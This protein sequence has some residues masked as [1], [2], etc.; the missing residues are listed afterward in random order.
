M[1][2]AVFSVML[3]DF[4]DTLGTVTGLA[5][6]VGETWLD[7]AGRLPRMVTVLFV[8]SLGALFGGLFSTS[9]N[10]T[11]IESGAG[12]AEGART[13]LA[14]VV[15]GICFLLAVFLAPFVV[16][17][18]AQATAGALLIVAFLMFQSAID[19]DW[20]DYEVAVPALLTMTVMPFTYSITNGIGFGFVSYVLIKLFRGKV[21]EVHPLLL[22]VAVAFLA[23]FL[24]G[25]H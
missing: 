14:S 12:I 6:R 4:F 15:T 20:S 22:V 19:I 8:D 24:W 11:Y 13:G 5:E 17:V 3:S 21:R 7:K 1:L 23:Y 9:S 25:Y 18:P 10:T 16:M 2:L